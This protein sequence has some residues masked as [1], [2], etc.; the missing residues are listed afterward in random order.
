MAIRS[1][2][3]TSPARRFQTSSDFSEVTKSTPEKT[4]LASKPKTGGRN[5][6]GRKTSRHRGGGHK[7][8]YRIVDFKR[9]KDGVTAKVAAIEYDPNRTCRIALLHYADG[10]KA[11]ILAPRG[12]GVGDQVESGQGA[13]IKPGNAMP[14]RYIP[15]GTTIHNVE[16][17]PGQGGK[18]GRSAGIAVQLVA[19]E[20]DFA[21]LRMPST[22]MRRVPIDCRATVGEVGNSE[23]EL[24][25]IGKA[26]RNRWKGV[27]PQTRGVA[28][29]PVDH[30]LGGGEGRT[31]GGRPAV[32]P[33]GK[34]EGRTRSKKK[35][36]QKMIVRRRRSGRGRR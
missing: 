34:P 5:A 25:K 1:R 18:V 22:E 24:V 13:D 7:Q 28:M 15:V 10:E 4:L 32:S 23:H 16:L 19:K 30:P 20:G 29:N 31:S 3:P 2:K 26:G 17:R 33:W 11:Y 36:S 12:L 35:A 9:T 6:Y 27:K 21:T 14:L 8:R